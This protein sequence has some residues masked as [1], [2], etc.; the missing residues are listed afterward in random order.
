MHEYSFDDSPNYHRVDIEMY[1]QCKKY[2][3]KHWIHILFE[4]RD[5]EDIWL[6]KPVL[7]NK[8]NSTRL[9][10]D[11]C[12]ANS[13]KSFILIMSIILM[14]T[15]FTLTILLNDIW[16]IVVAILVMLLLIYC[17]VNIYMKNK[18]YSDCALLLTH[19]LCKCSIKN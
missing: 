6:Y 14:V 9:R 13:T 5:D 12:D 1:T 3:P 17:Q 10:M 19:D 2:L 7:N 16:W 4:Y 11:I 18:A 8:E 15:C